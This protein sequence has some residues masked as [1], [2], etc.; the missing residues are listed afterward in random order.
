MIEPIVDEASHK[1]ALE[2]IESLW[3]APDTTPEAAELDAL[4]T[5]VDAHE[6]KHFPIPPP[7][8]PRT[9]EARSEKKTAPP[10]ASRKAGG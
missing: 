1:K 7:E 3:D 6:R 8:P 10:L 5:L 9:I 4:A 2:R